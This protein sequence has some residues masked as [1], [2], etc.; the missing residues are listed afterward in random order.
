MTGFL[1]VFVVALAVRIAYLLVF[2]WLRPKIWGGTEFGLWEMGNI[3]INLSH[4]R[5]FSSPFFAGNLPT[6]WMC[7][8]VPVLWASVMKL[9]GE[10]SGRTYRVLVVLQ[11][12][13]SALSVS[14]YWLIARYLAR[15]VPGLP[16]Y[17]A[18]LVAIVFCLWPESVMRFTLLW[19]FVWQELILVA[20]IYAGLWW[21][22][23]PNIYSGS[24]LG[25][26]GGLMALINVT[27]LPIFATALVTPLIENK[28]RRAGILRVAVVSGIVTMA[29]IGPWLV[30][31]ALRFGSFVPIRSNAAYELFQ[32]NNPNGS[33]CQQIVSAHPTQDPH[34]LALYKSLGEI[35]YVRYSRARAFQYIK[36]HPSETALRAAE[37]I[38]VAWCT[39]IFQQWPWE[40]GKP[41]SGQGF[42]IT[43]VTLLSALVPLGIVIFGLI[44][45]RLRGLPHPILFASIFVFLPLPHYFTMAN[46]QYLQT[47][48]SWLALMAVIVL[49]RTRPRSG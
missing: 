29:I 11:I 35:E 8:L 14:F 21:C 44:T 34:E 32:G 38:Y 22:D 25:A 7:P 19:Y 16:S 24:T 36:A 42:I 1:R 6:A 4:G 13:P 39:D 3:A 37:R 26:L 18:A 15:R 30:R 10:A 41:Y 43:N 20:L 9:L 2:I 12:V 40:P 46:G 45:G 5:G 48:R 17:T 23:E 33:V 27:P 49:V 28:F 31:D 47:L